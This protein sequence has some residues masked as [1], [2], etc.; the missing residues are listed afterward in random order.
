MPESL[1]E[2]VSQSQKS[3]LAPGTADATGRIR[4]DVLPAIWSVP[5]LALIGL[6][7]CVQVVWT[8]GEGPHLIVTRFLGRPHRSAIREF[9]N[10]AR[11]LGPSPST[12][13][14][15]RSA[16]IDYVARSASGADPPLHRRS[17]NA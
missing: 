5:L 14:R 16:R 11:D 17:A 8:H 7:V 2:S 6:P 13:E 1:L 4:S 9:C 3:G 12:G 10:T 15:S